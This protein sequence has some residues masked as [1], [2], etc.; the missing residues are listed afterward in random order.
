MSIE[1]LV[2][3]VGRS[4]G[5]QK[6][7]LRING[8]AHVTL[9][10]RDN[11]FD[12]V[13]S[14]PHFQQEL[15]TKLECNTPLDTALSDSTFSWRGNFPFRTNR[16]VGQKKL[17]LAPQ[18]GELAF[19]LPPADTGGAMKG[20]EW[21]DAMEQDAR[22]ATNCETLEG[23]LRR[24]SVAQGRK[25]MTPAEFHMLVEG[26]NDN[27]ED[28]RRTWIR[29]PRDGM[30]ASDVADHLG[31][32][33]PVYHRLLVQYMDFVGQGRL[34]DKDGRKCNI[35]SS[36]NFN[37]LRFDKGSEFPS[38][39]SGDG[40]TASKSTVTRTLAQMEKEGVMKREKKERVW[41]YWLPEGEGVCGALHQGSTAGSSAGDAAATGGAAAGGAAT[42]GAVTVGRSSVGE[43]AS[44]AEAHGYVMEGS[45]S[46]TPA[47]SQ[48]GAHSPFS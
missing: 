8:F 6:G 41:A 26:S 22:E 18:V 33:P 14:I 25:K 16:T 27:L 36:H 32:D 34:M 23:A 24:I 47:E 45:S 12:T 9:L 38:P 35:R 40:H 2:Q 5:E 20:A 13:Q 31:V 43:G 1:K 4:T 3:S 7:R 19:N 39:D 46:D 11:D 44:G 37:S 28:L 30:T 21:R 17:Q 10:M 29:V 42:G 15:H 48:F